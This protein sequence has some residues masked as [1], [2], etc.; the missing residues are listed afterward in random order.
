MV[1]EERKRTAGTG[2]YGTVSEIRVRDF[3]QSL[4][5]RRAEARRRC[6]RL[7]STGVASR[8]RFPFG[9]GTKVHQRQEWNRSCGCKSGKNCQFCRPGLWTNLDSSRF[10][11]KNTHELIA[12]PS[13]GRVLLAK[14]IGS[15]PRRFPAGFWHPNALN[16]ALIWDPR[17]GRL[18]SE[19]NG[20]LSADRKFL[21]WKV[22]RGGV[23]CL[24]ANRP[25]A[26]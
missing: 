22:I 10:V 15:R 5:I 25:A 21:G 4:P 13:F 11:G 26:M 6:R 18:P 9:G 8:G 16:R 2:A 1:V 23:V 7:D 3:A 14:R 17:D 24:T 19:S 12:L 20:H